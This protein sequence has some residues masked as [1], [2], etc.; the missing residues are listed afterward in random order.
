MAQ[1]V[2]ILSAARTAIGSFM[3]ALSTTPAPRLGAVAIKAALQRA[4]IKAEQLDQ[5]IMGNVLAAGQGQASARQAAIY[6]DIPKHV[7]ATT[8]N[9]VCGSGM[10][11]VNFARQ[12][13]LAGDS[14]VAVVGGMEN[15][16]LAPYLSLVHAKAIVWAKKRF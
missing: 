11:S 8:I 7:G 2:V 5:V 14:Q 12:A 9:K 10:Q 13:I 6:A 3:G 15:M 16:S 4:N 1:E